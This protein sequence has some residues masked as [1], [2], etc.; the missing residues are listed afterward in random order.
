[1]KRRPEACD[2]PAYPHGLRYAR[3]YP[4]GWRCDRHAPR[5]QRT[6]TTGSHPN[7]AA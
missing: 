4:C 2:V 7:T 6:P 5:A 3:L 1:M